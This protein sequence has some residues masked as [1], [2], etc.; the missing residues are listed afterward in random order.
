VT[1]AIN[2]S[3][4]ALA[5]VGSNGSMV[6]HALALSPSG[7]FIYGSRFGLSVNAWDSGSGM[8]THLGYVNG[9]WL[10]AIATTNTYR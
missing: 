5:K 3:T 8:L 6:P 4:G 1:Y 9:S 7:K 10:N 2:E